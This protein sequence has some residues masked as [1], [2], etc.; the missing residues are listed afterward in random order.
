M[1]TVNSERLTVS[2]SGR[3]LDGHTVN[4]RQLRRLPNNHLTRIDGQ[5]G[6]V[7]WTGSGLLKITNPM[8]EKIMVPF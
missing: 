1:E 8:L 5:I 3:L 2:Q 7:H 4:D 6:T